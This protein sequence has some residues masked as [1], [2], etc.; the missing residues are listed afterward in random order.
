M[1]LRYETGIA[2]LIQFV[3]L[4]ILNIGTGTVSAVTGCTNGTSG[5][6]TSLFTSAVFFVLISIWFGF[7]WIL[8]FAAQETRSRRLAQA[9][10]IAEVLVIMVATLNARHH[11]DMLNLVTSLLDICLA[12]WVIYLAIRLMQSKGGRVV[13]KIK[14]RQRFIKR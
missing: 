7:I 13:K 3:T 12:L 2:T 6:V 11:T 1:T 14:V 8:G 9:L 4:T 5:C 10:I